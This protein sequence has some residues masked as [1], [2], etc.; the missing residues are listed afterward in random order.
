M[1]MA[2]FMAASASQK[3]TLQV[4]RR[5]MRI[6]IEIIGWNFAYNYYGYAGVVSNTLPK[7]RGGETKPGWVGLTS[8]ERRLRSQIA[9]ML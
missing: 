3:G 8:E 5:G 2:A 7:G 4:E 1:C 6:L 9:F